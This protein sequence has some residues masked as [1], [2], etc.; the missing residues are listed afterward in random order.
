MLAGPK[1]PTVENKFTGLTSPEWPTDTADIDQKLVAQGR[2]LYMD[3]CK[4]CHMA[5]IK[6]KEFWELKRWLPP[7]EFGDRVLDLEQIPLVHRHRPLTSGRNESPQS[8][9]SCQSRN[10]DGRIGPALGVLVTKTVDYLYSHAAG[11]QR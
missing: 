11:V 1:P 9:N 10:W 8:R 5:P 7:N 3:R 4:G 6:D 2:D